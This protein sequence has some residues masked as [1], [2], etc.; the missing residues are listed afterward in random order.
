MTC[1]KV[2]ALHNWRGHMGYAATF[3]AISPWGDALATILALRD[4]EGHDSTLA[5]MRTDFD[6]GQLRPQSAP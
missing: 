5:A 6:P 1:G 4:L 2:Q 3:P